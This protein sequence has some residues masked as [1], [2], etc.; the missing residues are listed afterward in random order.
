MC[1][2]RAPVAGYPG[3]FLPPTTPPPRT[4]VTQRRGAPGRVRVHEQLIGG[5]V[6]C[7][8]GART[9]Q[10]TRSPQ[11]MPNGQHK[12]IHR[13]ICP[14][15]HDIS[16]LHTP[17]HPNERVCTPYIVLGTVGKGGLNILE[18][19][20]MLLRCSIVSTGPTGITPSGLRRVR[21]STTRYRPP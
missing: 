19:Q 9:S 6:A 15:H 10:T 20:N 2:R 7:C 14:L 5:S 18:S 12:G 3:T 1:R 8:G 16:T 11:R 13:H 17:P 4:R 21:T